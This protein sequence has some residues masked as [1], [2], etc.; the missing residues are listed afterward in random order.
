MS[1]P[2]PLSSPYLAGSI[3]P[4]DQ[5]LAS[6]SNAGAVAG[7]VYAT[8]PSF[9]NS[10]TI[11][12][13]STATYY[14]QAAGLYAT[15]S[16]TI[17]N[18]GRIDGGLYTSLLSDAAE[19]PVSFGVANS[20]TITSSNGTTAADFQIGVR[21]NG[22]TASIA[23]SGTISAHS[24]G[25]AYALNLYIQSPSQPFA[26]AL[27]NTG[28]ISAT[29]MPV[30]GGNYPTGAYGLNVQGANLSGT[31]TNAAGGTISATG[32]R[33]YAILAQDSALNLINAG[34]IS[35]VGTTRS[36]AIVTYGAFDNMI[37]N[38]GTITGDLWLDA[39]TDTVD[40]AGTINGL[41]DLYASSSG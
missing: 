21:E 20:G 30:T 15:Q 9:T 5:V 23:N 8:V 24:P 18:S 12:V 4:S 14:K 36:A 1:V 31:I 19:A 3:F 16:M 2:Y 11:G 29:A 17:E 7:G 35:A 32:D 27:T 41:V 28:T 6:L 25:S 39:G 37:R 26:Y 22:G 33:A 38:N 40:N 13:S 34:T 10:G